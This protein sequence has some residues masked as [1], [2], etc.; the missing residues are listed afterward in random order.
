MFPTWLHTDNKAH[1]KNARAVWYILVIGAHSARVG[2]NHNIS[3]YNIISFARCTYAIYNISDNSAGYTYI[4]QKL[5][6]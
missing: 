1:E 2:K 4:L 6:Q 5:E 3:D